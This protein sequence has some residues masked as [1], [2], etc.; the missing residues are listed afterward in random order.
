MNKDR[1]SELQKELVELI[2]NYENDSISLE[3]AVLEFTRIL[4]MY[5]SASNVGFT[6]IEVLKKRFRDKLDKIEFFKLKNKEFEKQV[7]M[8]REL[9]LSLNL[10]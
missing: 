6:E 3:N 1:V 5:E 10:F 4:K 7:L 2:K 9:K 8:N